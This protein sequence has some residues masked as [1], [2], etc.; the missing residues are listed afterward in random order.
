MAAKQG[1]VALK[2][3]YSGQ[4]AEKVLPIYRRALDLNTFGNREILSEMYKPLGTI[5]SNSGKEKMKPY[6]DFVI[7]E[8]EKIYKESPHDLKNSLILAQLYLT[9]YEFDSNNLSRAE[10][11][12]LNYLK[13]APNKF[14]S[15]YSLALISLQKQ[16]FEDVG[17]YLDKA[18]ML[19]LHY[20]RS[21]WEAARIHFM[22]KDSINGRL[23]LARALSIFDRFPWTNLIRADF[24]TKEDAQ[25]FVGIFERLEKVETNWN[26]PSLILTG[27]YGNL[28][29]NDKFIYYLKEAVKISPEIKKDMETMFNIKLDNM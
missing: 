14:D 7:K 19:N 15:Y 8:E 28:K 1:L 27:L 10:N 25:W 6:L 5:R 16:K 26:Y 12:Y 9:G 11:I 24:L 4:S 17:S 23:L 3:E 2:M 21:F 29:N 18:M 13:K 20:Y 22:V